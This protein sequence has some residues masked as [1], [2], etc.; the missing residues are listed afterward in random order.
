MIPKLKND[1]NRF[2]TRAPFSYDTI[3]HGIL[4]SNKI[5]SVIRQYR[6]SMICSR[7]LFWKPRKQNAGTFPVRFECRILFHLTFSHGYA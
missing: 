2:L 1:V 4:D 6:R 3:S 5:F 7:F